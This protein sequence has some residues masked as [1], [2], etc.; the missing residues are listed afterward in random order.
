MNQPMNEF[1]KHL[2]VFMS[3]LI[4]AALE[5]VLYLICVFQLLLGWLA[6]IL[7]NGC[8]Q[9]GWKFH[10]AGWAFDQAKSVMAKKTLQGYQTL[11]SPGPRSRVCA[12]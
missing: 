10:L 12:R 6:V 1:L 9:A 4:V 2:V 7:P 11:C 8:C 5:A 3:V